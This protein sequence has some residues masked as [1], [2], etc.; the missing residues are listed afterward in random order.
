[1]RKIACGTCLLLLIAAGGICQA[2]EKSDPAARARAIAP[3]IDEATF[4][5]VHADMSRLDPAPFVPVVAELVPGFQWAGQEW[6][7]KAIEQI[8]GLLAALARTGCKDLYVVIS[9]RSLDWPA[10]VVPLPENIDPTRLKELVE[11][12]GSLD[13]GQL[14]GALV[15]APDMTFDR[16]RK[17]PPDP[18][19][20]LAQAF[21][22]AGDTAG[23]VLILPPKHAARV[24]DDVLPT[25]PDELGGGPS[26]VVTRGLLWV[27]IG[28]NVTPKVSHRAVTQARDNQAAVALREM[29]VR[30]TRLLGKDKE[31]RKIVTNYDQLAPTIVPEVEGDKLVLVH[32]EGSPGAA[33]LKTTLETLFAW[34]GSR[35]K[36]PEPEE[37]RN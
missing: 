30:I 32:A 37:K 9:F 12:A 7:S 20:E 29:W 35:S 8:K 6:R 2:A 23:Q 14:L 3:F 5:I 4:A 22:A 26:S 28:V 31:F 10:L 18:R 36:P 13:M 33:A 34:A 11:E 21:E 25:L 15:V 24:L 16:L 19:P 1:M 17:S 27:A